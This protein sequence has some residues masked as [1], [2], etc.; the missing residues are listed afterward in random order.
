MAEFDSSNFNNIL[1]QIIEKS[2]FT[3]RQVEII[4]NQKNLIESNFGISKGAYYRQLGQ[5]RN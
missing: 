3:E 2:L 1:R 4:L 5:S